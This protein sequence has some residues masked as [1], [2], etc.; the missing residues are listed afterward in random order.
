MLIANEDPFEKSTPEA[1]M[2]A[3]PAKLSRPDGSLIGKS[4]MRRMVKKETRYEHDFVEV[5]EG[6]IKSRGGATTGI[7]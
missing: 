4:K 6:G 2:T 3:L 7:G 5:G 1:W